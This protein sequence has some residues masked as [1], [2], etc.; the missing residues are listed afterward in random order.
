MFDS[1]QKEIE[2]IG[3][4]KFSNGR[5]WIEINGNYAIYAPED[6]PFEGAIRCPFVIYWKNGQYMRA[7]AHR[8]NKERL[9]K[10]MQV[11]GVEEYWMA[12]II[13]RNCINSNICQ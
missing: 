3:Q 9:V 6:Y 8:F 2:R 13:L 12:E 7:S 11:K 10:E 4:V 1:R 5:Q